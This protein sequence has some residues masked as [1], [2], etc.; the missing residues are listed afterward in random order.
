MPRQK[1]QGQ[2]KP[3]VKAP[4]DMGGKGHAPRNK[5]KKEAQIKLSIGDWLKGI[6]CKVYDEKN[7]P[8]R[9]DWDG[10]FQVENIQRG[11]KPD[12]VIG[13]RIADPYSMIGRQLTRYIAL[14][15]KPGYKHV[16]LVN[17]FSDVIGYFTD[18][19]WGTRYSI[20]GEGR[21]HIDAIVLATAF[22]HKGYL[23]G[24]EKQ[25]G[26]RFI[27]QVSRKFY[28]MTFT[29]SRLLWSQ[30]TDITNRLN[31]LV[32][33][34]GAERRIE[35]G[36]NLSNPPDVGVLIAGDK[37]SPLLLISQTPYYWAINGIC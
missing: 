19:C 5:E 30:R 29:L 35:K 6:G 3:E 12:L 8:K 10:T 32:K 33:I 31:G 37:D 18:Y 27:E 34:P 15:I 26:H 9:P 11:R 7:N 4:P 14:E 2:L 28:P 24:Y 17:G 13:C 22:S 20:K 16:D 21:I 23:Y 25:F 1:S 36:L